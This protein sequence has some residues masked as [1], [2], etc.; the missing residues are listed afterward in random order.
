[1]SRGVVA[2]VAVFFFFSFFFWY[3]AIEPWPPAREPLRPVMRKEEYTY[4]TDAEMT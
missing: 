3:G 1:M 4:C 2:V